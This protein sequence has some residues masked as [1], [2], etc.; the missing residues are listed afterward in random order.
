MIFCLRACAPR[1][2]RAIVR[3]FSHS[4]SH[5]S[6][7]SSRRIRTLSH[8]R[9]GTRIHSLPSINKDAFIIET[10]DTLFD[11]ELPEGRC[12]GLELRSELPPNQL[13]S[14][15]A[16]ISDENHW[17]R[18]LLHTDEVSYGLAL[19]SDA[20]RQTFFLGRLA[21]RRA[22]DRNAIPSDRA[23]LKD[24]YGRPTLPPG[25]LGSISHKKSTGAAMV[26][27]DLPT[28]ELLLGPRFGIGVDIEKAQAGSTNVARRVLTKREKEEIGRLPVSLSQSAPGPLGFHR[29]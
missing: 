7:F 3:A 11:L 13:L 24:S 4:S 9:K 27:P 10:L 5:L 20:V 16:I 21:M 22:L 6:S 2:K 15:E 29:D 26:T 28:S 17:I 23:I 8:Y 14:K 25:F 18:S 1:E 12:V 19:A